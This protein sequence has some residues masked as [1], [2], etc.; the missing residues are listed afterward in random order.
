MNYEKIPE[1]TRFLIIGLGLMGGSYARAL[2][3]QGYTVEAIDKNIDAIEYAL[4]KDIID[5]GSTVTTEE[6]VKRADIIVFALY[7]HVFLEWLEKY[8]DFIRKDTLIT[9][10]TGVKT[11]IVH[12]VQEKL[13]NKAEFIAAH[14]MAGREV[15]G[16]HNSNEA[17]FKGA[18]YIVVPTEKN[19]EHA[20]EVCCELGEILDFRKISVL[21][22]EEHDTMIAFL[23]QLTH[24]IA[25][26]LMCT[27]G[28]P[29]LCDYTGDSFRD[30]TRI[31]NINDVM[32]SEL[33]LLNKDALLEQTDAFIEQITKMRDMI[34]SGDREGIR[35]MMKTST[36]RRKRF[37]KPTS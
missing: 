21:S 17:I 8:R 30:L 29:K 4:D 18:N 2:K 6:A 34:A 10:V 27:N 33:F 24:A 7:P 26:A 23:S 22:P 35:D 1:S 15:G 32:W 19:T 31:A 25:V 5:V 20:I 16:V 36:E 13:G 28:D 14:P 12:D 9:D 37:N 3:K 11:V